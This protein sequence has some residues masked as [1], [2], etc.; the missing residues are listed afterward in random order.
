MIANETKEKVQ[1]EE[2]EATKKAEETSEMAAEAQR[3]L[4]E[5][6]PALV[7]GLWFVGDV[8]LNGSQ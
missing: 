2:I 7:S 1:I 6:L 4:D 3:D 5:A 8:H